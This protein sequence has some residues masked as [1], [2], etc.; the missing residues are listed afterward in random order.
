MILGFSGLVRCARRPGEQR[1]V[2]RMGLAWFVVC[3]GVLM[4][5]P[6][7]WAQHALVLVVPICLGVGFLAREVLSL[8]SFR[9]GPSGSHPP[10]GG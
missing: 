3:L 10:A 6:T 8:S 4:V 7:R 9:F 1:T 5:W 2:A